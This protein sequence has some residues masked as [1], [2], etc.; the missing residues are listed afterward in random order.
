MESRLVVSRGNWWWRSPRVL[1]GVEDVQCCDRQW[2]LDCVP[3]AKLANCR[4]KVDPPPKRK[5]HGRQF[6]WE[7]FRNAEHVS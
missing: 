4:L 3:S 1:C 5:D 7:G 6:I 2:L